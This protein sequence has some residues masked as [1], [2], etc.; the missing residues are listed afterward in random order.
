[1]HVKSRSS[2]HLKDVARLPLLILLLLLLPHKPVK[3]NGLQNRPLPARVMLKPESPLNHQGVLL[4]W[5]PWPRSGKKWRLPVD[6]SVRVWEKGEGGHIAQ[7]LVHG[8][9][10]PEDVSAFADGTEESMGRRLQWHTIA[11]NSLYL[12]F[13][14]HTHSHYCRIYCFFTLPCIS[15]RYIAVL[16]IVVSLGRPASSHPKWTVE[17]PF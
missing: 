10:L 3:D 8:L 13:H 4:C 6:V 17:G 16:I 14:F 1:M 15:P 2:N 11:I 12:Y 5:S 7:S 9:L